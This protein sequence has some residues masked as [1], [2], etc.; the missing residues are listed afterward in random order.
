MD[1][2]SL[3]NL[4]NNDRSSL[5]SLFQDILSDLKHISVNKVVSYLRYIPE[6]CWMHHN[7]IENR[8]LRSSHEKNFT[9]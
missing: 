3:N 7:S 9:L 6:Q 2:N 1:Y 5:T 4:D 8:R